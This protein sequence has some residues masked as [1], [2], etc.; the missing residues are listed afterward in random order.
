MAVFDYIQHY[1]AV[2][3][4]VK[5]SGNLRMTLY[6]LDEVYSQTLVPLVMNSTTNIAKTQLVNFTQQR[7]KLRI[8]TTAI[9]EVFEF[10]QISV[11]VKPIYTSLPQ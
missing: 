5:G 11:Y 6:S 10:N 8:E 7:A 3:V 4:R 1:N 9:D 2:R